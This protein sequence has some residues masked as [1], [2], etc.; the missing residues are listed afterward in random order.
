[1]LRCAHWR[2]PGRGAA[3]VAQ[4]TTVV[5]RSGRADAGRCRVPFRW[6]SGVLGLLLL[7]ATLPAA[8][9]NGDSTFSA[10]LAD[11]ARSATTLDDELQVEVLESGASAR[12]LR[13]TAEESIP[14]GRLT[15]LGRKLADGVLSQLSLHRRLP[16]I[17]FESDPR[18]VQFF[19][20]HPDVAVAIWRAMDISDLQL[21]QTGPHRYRTDSGDGS[22]GS[23]TVLISDPQRQLV[24]CE[25]TFKSPVLARPLHAS[26][27]MWVQ[28]E[29]QRDKQGREYVQCTA[30][31]FVAFTS[32]TLETAARVA[33]PV[34]NRIADRNFQE[35]AMF[36]RMMH[37]GMTR[38]PGWIEQL[39]ANLNGVSPERSQS[40]LDTTARVY[41][42]A[43][44]RVTQTGQP[45][46]ATLTPEGLRLPPRRESEAPPAQTAAFEDAVTPQGIPPVT[47]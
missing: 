38:Q 5:D 41:V 42:D 29:F 34:S 3:G 11:Q 27:L 33:S 39:A 16:V 28:V 20:Q 21:T 26:A 35:V 9:P 13:R 4:D 24:H 17:R 46:Q 43:Q 2:A 30:D 40:L 25:G 31:V 36:L 10:D 1:M 45:G 37:L 44:R 22:A 15:P 19:L 23:L 7:T 14:V 18:V 8:D 32:V 6:T 12:R 47:R